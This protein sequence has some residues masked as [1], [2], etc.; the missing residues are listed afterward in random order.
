MRKD[1]EEMERNGYIMEIDFAQ[2]T[3]FLVTVSTQPG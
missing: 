2:S 1:F 3:R